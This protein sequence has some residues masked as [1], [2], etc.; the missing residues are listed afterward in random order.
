M[1]VDGD[2]DR[3]GTEGRWARRKEATRAT[4]IAVARRLFD[5]Q[6][7]QA[8]TVQ[9][10][11][12]AAE[13]SER[14]FFRYF[15]SKEDLLLTDMVAVLDEVASCLAVRP[16]G[17]APLEAVHQALRT[18][19]LTGADGGALHAFA[20]GTGWTAPPNRTRLA[21]AYMDW[22]D[23]LAQIFLGRFVAQG[24]D[25]A[26]PEVQLRAALTARV[27]VAATRSA[28]RHYRG[29]PRDLRRGTRGLGDLMASVFALAAEGCPPPGQGPGGRRTSVRSGR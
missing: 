24:A 4:I 19:A 10:I 15:E 16:L 25:P 11:A 2:G 9:Q 12:E 14:T 27:A 21:R 8:T 3:P 7:F 20:S 18:A 1:L 17:E 6:G 22:E 28:L 29:L 26:A 5:E 13:V 23:R